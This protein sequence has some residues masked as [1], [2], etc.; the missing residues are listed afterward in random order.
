MSKLIDRLNCAFGNHRYRAADIKCVSM[1]NDIVSVEQ[2]C[3]FC[4][5][6]EHFLTRLSTME[7]YV[8]QLRQ[9]AE[10]WHNV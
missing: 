5:F 3:M 6:T 9:E 10:Q 8:E 4:G 2:T 1:G 7:Q